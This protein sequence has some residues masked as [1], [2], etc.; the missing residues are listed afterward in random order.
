[1]VVRQKDKQKGASGAGG[2]S[3]AD[4]QPAGGAG[5]SVFDEQTSG[6]KELA[7][8]FPV[9]G[10][11][12][13]V[14]FWRG[15]WL[16]EAQP[17]GVNVLGYKDGRFLTNKITADPEFV[18]GKHYVK[19]TGREL[20]EYKA[21]RNDCGD[22]PQSFQVARGGAQSLLLLTEDGTRLAAMKAKTPAG[23]NARAW[24]VK[25]WEEIDRTGR[26]VAPGAPGEDV[27]SIIRRE[28]AA[29]TA[30]V[31]REFMSQFVAAFRQGG[32]A[33]PSLPGI[34]PSPLELRVAKLERDFATG[35]IGPT[36]AATL[37]KDLDGA[38]R[39]YA[40]AKGQKAASVR[41]SWL[42]QMEKRLGHGGKDASWENLPTNLHAMAQR[43]VS[44]FER[45]AFEARI[46]KAKAEATA[47]ALRQV[48]IPDPTK[49]GGE[50]DTTPAAA[51]SPAP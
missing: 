36:A 27:T 12:L 41:R 2:A 51:T 39:G 46:A 28:V 1:M 29:V 49:P 42:N 47:A 16:T 38:V 26:Y 43:L 11:E 30:T 21:F 9:T 35:V 15:L 14:S 45:Q 4:P 3:V 17:F 8:V 50:G 20:A 23:V 19:L 24:L 48:P 32:P 22:S 7:R 33:Q 40:R 18:E 13:R 31:F 25:V 6:P 37:L 5:A 34:E 44:G 10:K